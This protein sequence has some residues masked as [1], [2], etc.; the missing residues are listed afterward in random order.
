V[1]AYE[2]VTQ[3]PNESDPPLPTL[4]EATAEPYEVG[5]LSTPEDDGPEPEG[6]W[7]APL[8]GGSLSP[9]L[10]GIAERYR[11]GAPIDI[12]DHAVPDSR[13]VDD[14]RVPGW[15]KRVLIWPTKVQPQPQ[16]ETRA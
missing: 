2:D 11:P 13:L 10:M 6:F 1:R 9:W 15:T 16:R 8:T 5:L 4:D 3:D 12:R 7:D 14:P